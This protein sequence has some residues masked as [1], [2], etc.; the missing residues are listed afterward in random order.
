MHASISQDL[1]KSGSALLIEG[2]H[3]ATLHIHKLFMTTDVKLYNQADVENSCHNM[4][5]NCTKAV[6]FNVEC[7]FTVLQYITPT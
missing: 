3:R 7:V 2:V 6:T 4:S 5:W 1:C